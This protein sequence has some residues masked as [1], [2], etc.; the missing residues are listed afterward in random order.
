MRRGFKAV[1]PLDGVR[2]HP[3]SFGP[4]HVQPSVS[5]AFAHNQLNCARFFADLRRVLGAT[6]QQVAA[7]LVTRVETIE[8][9]E[10]GEIA[11]LPPWPET[12]RVVMAYAASGGIDGRPVLSAIAEM[13]REWEVRRS[14]SAPPVQAFLPPPQYQSQAQNAAPRL[15]PRLPVERIRRAGNAIAHGAARLPRE[16]LAQVRKRPDRAFYAV[17]FP[18]VLLVVAANTSLLATPLAVLTKPV[19]SAAQGV[20][21]YYQE[22]FAPV[23]EGFKWIETDDPRE[24]RGDKLPVEPR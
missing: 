2:A 15:S 6:P 5:P 21:T 18:L 23:R 4:A 22:R 8:A 7:Q 20:K 10:R 12:A 19:A 16:A 1:Q 24:R 14:Q 11:H 17:S 9:L 13:L 3:G